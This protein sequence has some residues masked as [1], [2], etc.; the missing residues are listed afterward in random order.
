MDILRKLKQ[1]F[2]RESPPADSPRETPPLSFS[3]PPRKAQP[4]KCPKCGSTNTTLR[5]TDWII[6]H[7]VKDNGRTTFACVCNDCGHLWDYPH[8]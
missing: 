5:M 3:E 1:L 2:R 4:R 8:N 7:Q 6:G